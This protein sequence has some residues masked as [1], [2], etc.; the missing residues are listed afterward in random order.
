MVSKE[1]ISEELQPRGI[2]RNNDH[3]NICQKQL[4]VTQNSKLTNQQ[5][6]EINMEEIPLMMER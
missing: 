3:R 5:K 6:I 2:E 4:N 1:V